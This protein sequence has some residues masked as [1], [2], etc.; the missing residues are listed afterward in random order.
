MSEQESPDVERLVQLF[1]EI[2]TNDDDVVDLKEL[3]TYYGKH[4]IQQRNIDQWL[5]TFD[6]NKDDR[7]TF[8][9]F[10]RGLGFNPNEL[11]I[12]RK[13]RIE[14][15]NGKGPHVASD[16]E[17]ISSTMSDYKI[18]ECTE[19]FKHLIAKYGG[20]ENKITEVAREFK[21]FLDSEY[22]R[23]WQVVIVSGSYWMHF[24]HEPMQS[25]Q[26]KYEKYI[27]LAWRTPS[28]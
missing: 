16:V 15:R 3:R 5:S 28:G 12:E 21:A 9:E 18:H 13:H 7:I 24:S 23:V 10:C 25:I 14:Q 19:K 11:R 20:N 27:C 8:N 22:S 1:L 6:E 26:F 2:D 4:G 17:M